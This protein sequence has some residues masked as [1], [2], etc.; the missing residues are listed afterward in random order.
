[1]AIWTAYTAAIEKNIGTNTMTDANQARSD[2]SH[3]SKIAP[4]TRTALLS[5]I[6][7]VLAA[8]QPVLA[9]ADGGGGG[10]GGGG[11]VCQTQMG[12]FVSAVTSSFGT[13]AIAGILIAIFI[14]V[15]ARP[16]IRSG[17]QASALND[18]MSKAFVGLIILILAIPIITWGLSFTPFAPSLSCIPF[19]G[20]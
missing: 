5:L 11:N 7:S 13:L 2:T 8:A 4:Y 6:L 12:G 10:G 17:G 18:I 15:A 20:G 14:G 9:Q 16:F 19:L 1:M 3:M